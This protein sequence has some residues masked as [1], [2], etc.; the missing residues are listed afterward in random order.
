MKG[1]TLGEEQAR[2]RY[3]EFNFGHGKFE[4]FIK[5]PSEDTEWTVGYTSLEYRGE[6]RTRV[7]DTLL[8]F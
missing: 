4:L 6:L 7:N 5:L 3:E 2:H 8:L 1:G